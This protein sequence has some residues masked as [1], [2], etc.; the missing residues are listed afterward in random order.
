MRGHLEC[1]QLTRY[2]FSEHRLA[3]RGLSDM[4]RFMLAGLMLSQSSIALAAGAT[5]FGV[6]LVP[7]ESRN[8]SLVPVRVEAVSRNTRSS[9]N[10]RGAVALTSKLG[11]VT[12]T[13]RSPAHNR[14]V[15]GV[16]NSFH[17]SGRAVDVVPRPGVRHEDIRTALV[18]AGYRLRESLDEGDHSHFAFDFGDSGSRQIKVQATAPPA[19]AGETPWRVVYA[20]GARR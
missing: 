7:S 14:F 13:Y 4:N 18:R 9:L 6:R 1:C 15:G 20:P 3:K 10:L 5:N 17:L 19:A 8:G 12:S 11:R 16:R 2:G